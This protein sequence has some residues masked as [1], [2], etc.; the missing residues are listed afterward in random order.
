MKK[1]LLMGTLLT[2]M[3]AQAQ[4]S[5]NITLYWPNERATELQSGTQY[6]I[7]NTAND[8]KDRSWF[9]YSDGSALKTTNESPLSF[10]TTEKKIF[11]YSRKAPNT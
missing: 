2:A 5:A 4:E 1:L 9:I 7:Y 3:T 11:L 8:G 6:F 10:A